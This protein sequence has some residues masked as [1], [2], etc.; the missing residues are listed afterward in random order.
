MANLA[1]RLA[2]EDHR[3]IRIRASLIDLSKL[4]IIQRGIQLG[5]DYGITNTCYDPKNDGRPCGDCD[6][7]YLR[8]KGFSEAGHV[9]PLS[10][11]FNSD[12]N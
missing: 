2:I 11:R 3:K 6:A 1:T 10:L 8:E 7:C 4:Q 9:Y 12:V 5:V